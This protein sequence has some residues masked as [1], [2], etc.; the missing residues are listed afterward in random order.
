M[1]DCGAPDREIHQ[2]AKSA[3]GIHLRGAPTKL[4]LEI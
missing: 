1:K 4:N 3:V 2:A